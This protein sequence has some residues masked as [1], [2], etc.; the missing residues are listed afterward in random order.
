MP[1]SSYTVSFNN[2]TPGIILSSAIV[3]P[4][5]GN[6]CKY[7]LAA[8]T[9]CQSTG[10]IGI[11]VSAKN[12]LGVGLSS[13]PEYIGKSL[14]YMCCVTY[15]NSIQYRERESTSLWYCVTILYKGQ[16]LCND[17]HVHKLS[18]YIII[19]MAAAS[20]CISALQYTRFSY[21]PTK[22]NV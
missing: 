10:S 20:T 14:L 9:Y 16:D 17:I 18:Y 22:L 2:S 4:C 5:V 7:Q 8:S 12:E 11:A 13:N 3:S 6:V 21:M 19:I 1:V 15:S